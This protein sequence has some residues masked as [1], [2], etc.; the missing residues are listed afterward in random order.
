MVWENIILYI[1]KN[2]ET[3]EYLHNYYLKYG[4]KDVINNTYDLTYDY[5]NEYLMELK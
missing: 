4:F 5:E 3:T 2:K 1:D